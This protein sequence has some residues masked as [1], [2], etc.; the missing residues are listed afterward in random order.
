MNTDDQ[1]GGHGPLPGTRHKAVPIAMASGPA[2]YSA[3]QQEMPVM[4]KSLADMVH[5]AQNWGHNIFPCSFPR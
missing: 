1:R 2:V 4:L 3:G 5:W